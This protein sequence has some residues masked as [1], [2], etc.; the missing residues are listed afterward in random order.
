MTLLQ[1]D[2]F[3]RL[4]V[5]LWAI[6]SVRRKAIHEGIF[7]SP[8]A[9]HGFISSYLSEPQVLK[10]VTTGQVIAATR[11]SHRIAPPVDV[12]KVNVDAAVGRSGDLVRMER[13]V[14]LAEI[15]QGL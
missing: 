4:V 3:V 1:E 8:H 11:P 15:T 6:W 10:P 13:W 9:I 7:Q 2:E 14:Q 12:S 5:S